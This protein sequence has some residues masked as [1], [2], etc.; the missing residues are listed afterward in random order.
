M[1]GVQRMDQMRIGDE[2]LVQQ[3]SRGTL[4]GNSSNN[5]KYYSKVY[6]FGHWDPNRETEFIH[7]WTNSSETSGMEITANHPV[8]IG[9]LLVTSHGDL[10][11]V[12]DIGKVLHSGAFV[13]C[14][15]SGMTVVNGI[16]ASNYI[17]LSLLPQQQQHFQTPFFE[18]QHSIQHAAY[19]PYRIY[20]RWLGGCETETY[21]E[22]SRLSRTV[23]MW[24]AN[25]RWFENLNDYLQYLLL[26]LVAVQGCFWFCGWSI[27]PQLGVFFQQ[28]SDTVL[29]WSDFVKKK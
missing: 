19:A 10:A 14:T 2:V 22:T 15:E 17:S 16:V 29:V 7:F 4:S 5:E 1:S 18:R 11:Q 24:L 26:Y 23:R 8:A 6:S 3:S 25:R 27:R 9:D 12:R 28:P 20:C 13:P 21:D